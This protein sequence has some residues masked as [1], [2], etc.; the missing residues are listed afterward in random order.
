VH[1]IISTIIKIPVKR[2]L[3][4][5]FLSTFGNTVFL[6]Y[7]IIFHLFGSVGLLYAIIFS[8]GNDIVL[9]TYGVVKLEETNTGKQVKWNFRNLFNPITMSFLIGLTMLSL[10]LKLPEIINSPLKTLGLTTTPL[11]MLFIGS[12]LAQTKLLKAGKNLSIWA[13]CL[14]KMI[15]IPLLLI[16]LFKLITP[17][18][19]SSITLIIYVF[20]L[21][22]A[23][24][25]QVI[26][27][28]LSEKYHS[29]TEYVAQT[30]FITI[31]VSVVTLPLVYF[32]LNG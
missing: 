19:S 17:F 21:Q 28:V 24:P 23:M 7:P 32:F 5:T 22:S 4:H 29:D 11:A 3:I 30:I 27:S 12:V 15:V 1:N 9:F 6:G 20:I 26:L 10:N 13:I 18:I 16:Y 8:I 14:T 25:S 31:L 2:K